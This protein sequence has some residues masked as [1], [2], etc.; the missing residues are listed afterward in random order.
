MDRLTGPAPRALRSADSGDA[1]EAAV[2]VLFR[3]SYPSL[4]RIAYALLGTREGAEDAVQ[5]AFVSLYRHWSG[6]RDQRAA[7]TYVRSAVLNRCRSRI[8]T[9]VRDSLRT[10]GER[11]VPLHVAG[12]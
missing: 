10:S 5:D 3:R 2:E 1:A 9:R 11:A 12:S 8:R 6:L 4:L 7:E